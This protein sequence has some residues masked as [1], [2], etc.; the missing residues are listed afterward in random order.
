MIVEILLDMHGM[1]WYKGG[2]ETIEVKDE[3]GNS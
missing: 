1:T 2:V 3:K